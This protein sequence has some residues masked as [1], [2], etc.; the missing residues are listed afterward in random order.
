MINSFFKNEFIVS[1]IKMERNKINK[2]LKVYG[3]EAT[4]RIFYPLNHA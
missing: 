2:D 1:Q 4:W 3:A